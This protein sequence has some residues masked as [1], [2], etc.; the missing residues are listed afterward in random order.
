MGSRHCRQAIANPITVSIAVKT[1]DTID[2]ISEV[3]SAGEALF[4]VASPVCWVNGK[5]LVV[6]FSN[7]VVL[8]ILFLIYLF[9]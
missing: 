2:M 3:P 4:C 1:S 8:F 6:L 5:V 7:V 9:F